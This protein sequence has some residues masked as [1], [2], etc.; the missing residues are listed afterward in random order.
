MD[1]P[2]HRISTCVVITDKN[3]NIL[4]V[5]LNYD[6]KKWSLPSG[7]LDY[8]EGMNEGA[9]REVKEETGLDIDLGDVIGIYHAVDKRQ[10][11]IAFRGIVVGGNLNKRTGETT[12]AIYWNI[13][14]LPENLRR[15]HRKVIKDALKSK[16]KAKLKI[17]RRK[18]KKPNPNIA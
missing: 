14:Q 15:I 8:E 2:K 16:K 7:V 18:T 5:H 9:I 4:L 12:D 6:R 13:D 17:I 11:V 1:I 3:D 10:V